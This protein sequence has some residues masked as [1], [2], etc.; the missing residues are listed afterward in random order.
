M[1][2]EMEVLTT[3]TPDVFF[4]AA[5]FFAWAIGFSSGG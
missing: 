1:G 5:C 4:A 3:L 2:V